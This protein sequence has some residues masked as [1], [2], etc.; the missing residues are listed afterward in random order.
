MKSITYRAV[1]NGN[2]YVNAALLPTSHR[3]AKWANTW[4]LVI[5]GGLLLATVTFVCL[6]LFAA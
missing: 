2:G 6:M 5:A 4:G 1:K 3:Q